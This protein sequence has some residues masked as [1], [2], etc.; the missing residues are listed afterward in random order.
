[1]DKLVVMNAAIFY[2]HCITSS[3]LIIWWQ[4]QEKINY[5]HSSSRSSILTWESTGFAYIGKINF[6]LLRISIAMWNYDFVLGFFLGNTPL[7]VAQM[8]P[9]I[10]FHPRWSHRGTARG[11]TYFRRRRLYRQISISHTSHQYSNCYL[12]NHTCQNVGDAHHI[13]R[14]S[15][16][17]GSITLQ[18]VIRNQKE[19]KSC[20]SQLPHMEIIT[21]HWTIKPYSNWPPNQCQWNK[22]EG[23]STKRRSKH[24]LMKLIIVTFTNSNP[25]STLSSN[26]KIH[27]HLTN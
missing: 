25:I 24:A 13:S 23:W 14:Y 22:K 20:H 26:C 27:N 7:L 1:M 3:C 11:P 16:T 9:V 18:N 10:K 6:E 15:S 12:G 21:D 5:Q 4:I 8:P 2:N 19:P 17:I